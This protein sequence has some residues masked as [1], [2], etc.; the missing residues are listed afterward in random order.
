MANVKGRIIEKAALKIAPEL[1]Q[2]MEEAIAKGNDTVMFILLFMLA[3]TN[4]FLDY[5]VIGSIPFIGDFV[6]IT[7]TIILTIVLWN[8]GGFIKW[9]V[10]I[11]IWA[12]TAIEIIPGGDIVPFYTLSMF[13]GWHKIKELAESGEKGLEEAAKGRL[14]PEVA[15]KFKAFLYE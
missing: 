2:K 10:R 5:L 15:E 4:D 3:A 6:D 14:S 8:I 12:A 13:Y 11:M 1:V 9:K 7:T